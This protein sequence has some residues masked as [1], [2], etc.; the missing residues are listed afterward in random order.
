MAKLVMLAASRAWHRAAFGSGD[1]AE[2]G[3]TADKRS[4][5]RSVQRAAC[6]RNPSQANADAVELAWREVQLALLLRLA[7]VS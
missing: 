4:W 2:K 5:K 1:P 6:A 7:S 3:R